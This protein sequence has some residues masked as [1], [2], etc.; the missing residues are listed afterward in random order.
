MTLTGVKRASPS[1]RF[2]TET[3]KMDGKLLPVVCQRGVFFIIRIC[4]M[5]M[6]GLEGPFQ[7]EN[8]LFPPNRIFSNSTGN[9]LYSYYV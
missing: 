8:M 4:Q 3:K 6:S 1:S 5:K 2:L 9:K 7:I